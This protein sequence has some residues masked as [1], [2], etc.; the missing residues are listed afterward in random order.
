MGVDD[1]FDRTLDSYPLRST[2]AFRGVHSDLDQT[3]RAKKKKCNETLIDTIGCD[4]KLM[5]TCG[6][7]S[8]ECAAGSHCLNKYGVGFCHCD[9]GTCSYQGECKPPNFCLDSLPKKELKKD[10][11]KEVKKETEKEN[12]PTKI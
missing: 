4:D 5:K 1:L 3:I 9:E 11:E 10:I 8:G 6:K 7:V 2:A 12:E